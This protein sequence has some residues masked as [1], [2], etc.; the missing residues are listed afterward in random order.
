MVLI[1]T[2]SRSHDHLLAVRL[3]PNLQGKL[4]SP[5]ASAALCVQL[6]LNGRFKSG[7][8]I[9]YFDAAGIRRE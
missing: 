3:R 7:E 2:A 8:H 5:M 6:L 1:V 9:D 4:V